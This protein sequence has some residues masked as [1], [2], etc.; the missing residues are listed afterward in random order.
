[1]LEMPALETGRLLIRPFDME[2]LQ[3]AHDLFD[4]ELRD[5]ELHSEKMETLAER[6]RWLEWIALNYEQLAMLNQPPYGDRA[7][8][9]KET[10]K[11]IG[12]CGYVPCLSAFEQMPNLAA[13]QPVDR[14]GRYSTE[15][16]LFYAISPAHRRRGYAAEAA[17]ALI[18]YAF[19]HLKLKRIIAET[20]YDNTGCKSSGYWNLAR[21]RTD[22]TRQYERISGHRNA[23]SDHR[24]FWKDWALLRSEFSQRS[25]CDRIGHP[26]RPLHQ[27]AWQHHGSQP[28]Q[29]I[30]FTNGCCHPYGVS[31]RNACGGCSRSQ[32]PRN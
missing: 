14:P 3:D 22:P 20:D 4:I 10:G 19:E 15:F 18:D 23:N 27:C 32:F 12:S 7:I 26:E 28:G 24:C 5:A 16:G 17:R 13:S 8:V 9:L 21:T 29:G 11:L 25:Y 31:T 2:D 6:A 1:L 30:M